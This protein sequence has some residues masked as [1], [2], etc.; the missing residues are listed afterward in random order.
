MAISLCSG[1]A[2]RAPGYCRVVGVHADG[3]EFEMHVSP[4]HIHAVREMLSLPISAEFRRVRHGKRLSGGSV[5]AA[6]G[7]ARRFGFCLRL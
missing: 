3:V 6:T 5:V 4:E 7:L 2:V 1:L